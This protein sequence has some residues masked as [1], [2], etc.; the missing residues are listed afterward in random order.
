MVRW[1]LWY[2]LAAFIKLLDVEGVIDIFCELAVGTT[3]A[4][5]SGPSSLC[6]QSLSL[7]LSHKQAPHTHTHTCTHTHTHTHTLWPVHFQFDQFYGF[8]SQL[9]WK[10][11]LIEPRWNN[12][13]QSFYRVRTLH[14]FI[15][16]WC[17]EYPPKKKYINQARMADTCTNLPDLPP[18]TYTGRHFKW[19]G[20]GLG[21]V[22]FLK[23]GAV[24]CTVICTV[25]RVAAFNSP[26]VDTAPTAELLWMF[27]LKPATRGA[28]VLAVEHAVFPHM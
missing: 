27:M 13:V 26:F 9:S 10:L 20:R 3:Y 16:A 12:R 11:Q 25:T 28:F 14:V 6:C 24:G 15:S 22:F 8:F 5:P 23:P 19:W 21:R 17:I 18:H 1:R 7:S 2:N 4:L